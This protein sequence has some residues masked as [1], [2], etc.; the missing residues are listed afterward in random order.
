MDRYITG[1]YALNLHHQRREEE[2]GGDWHGNL[3]DGITELPDR[4]VSYAGEG[5][6]ID[7]L[8][9]WGGYGIRDERELLAGMGIRVNGDGGGYAADYYRAVLDIIYYELMRYD[10]VRSMGGALYDYFDTREQREVIIKKISGER[11]RFTRK[12]V[13]SLWHWI[14]AELGEW[15]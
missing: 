1:L 8:A 3:W 4:R 13:G 5:C 11:G 12:A 2:P 14:K 10:G 9:V 7:T 6:G 15:D